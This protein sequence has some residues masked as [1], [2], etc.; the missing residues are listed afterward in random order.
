MNCRVSI[1]GKPFDIPPASMAM[2]DTISIIVLIPIYDGIVNPLMKRLGCELS[3]LQRIGWGFLVAAAAMLVCSFSLLFCLFTL[4]HPLLA[5]VLSSGY[6]CNAGMLF[7]SSCLS[8]Y[9]ITSP[10]SP[11]AF[12]WLQLQCW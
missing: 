11:G 9:T 12:L 7:V 8:F 10:I 4:F 3:M 6:R 2:F 1:A 5:P